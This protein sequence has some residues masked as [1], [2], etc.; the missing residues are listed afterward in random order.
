MPLDWKP[1]TK[2]EKNVT[3]INNKI[4]LNILL[5]LMLMYKTNNINA[6]KAQ[7]LDNPVDLG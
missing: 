1:Q 3:Q 6:N 2:I 7:I 4:F 5:L